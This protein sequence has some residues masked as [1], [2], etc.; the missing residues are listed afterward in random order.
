MEIDNSTSWNRG[1]F[2]AGL[3]ALR[4][5]RKV[6]DTPAAVE[7]VRRLA[8]R[9]RLAA[10]E[11]GYKEL[12]EASAAAETAVAGRLSSTVDIL[13]SQLGQLPAFRS[14]TS[15]GVL[16]IESDS[17]MSGLLDS[18]LK[19]TDRVTH[20]ARTVAEAHQVLEENSI[21][22]VVLDLSLPDGDGRDFLASMRERPATAMLPV[23]VLSG[24]A[25]NLPKAECYALGADAFFEKPVAPEVLKAAITARLHRSLE[26]RRE[27]RRDAL[28]GLP[29]KEAFRE[30]FQRLVSLGERTKVTAAVALLD[31]DRLS[32]INQVQGHAIGD[33]VLHCAAEALNKA[34]RKSDLLARW[35]GD[36][37]VVLLPSTPLEGARRAVSKLLQAMRREVFRAPNGQLIPLAFAAGVVPVLAR[38]GV[39]EV[40]AEAGRYLLM[41][42]QGTV[43]KP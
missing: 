35:G 22:L 31:F 40:V 29:N 19:G 23:I 42:K 20:M 14:A 21:E 37:F 41:A 16:I 4:A 43:E 18:L 32:L 10:T 17:K 11:Y 25:G 28:T 6:L 12:A 9:M 5:A 8:R 30:S 2:S 33:A 7:S 15:P 1:N 26:Y 27:S 36:E 3:D 39:D 13:I 24:L 34:L 38:M